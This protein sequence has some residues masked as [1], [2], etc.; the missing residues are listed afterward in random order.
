M[1]L[2]LVRIRVWVSDLIKAGV[3]VKV[4]VKVR[5]RVWVSDWMRLGSV[6]RR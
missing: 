4:R 2:K 3:G 1:G 5:V 6:S